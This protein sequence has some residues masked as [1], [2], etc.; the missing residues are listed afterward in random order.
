MQS[1]FSS[2]VKGLQPL[3]IVINLVVTALAL[4]AYSFYPVEQAN[5]PKATGSIT[6]NELTDQLTKPLITA[7][8]EPGQNRASQ[9]LNLSAELNNQFEYYLY[10]YTA[11]K[12]SELVYASKKPAIEPSK[13]NQYSKDDNTIYQQLSLNDQPVGELII[14][15]VANTQIPSHSA[16][17]TYVLVGLALLSL[18]ILTFYINAYLNKRIRKSSDSLASQLQVITESASYDSHVQQQLDLGLSAVASNINKLLDQVQ[19]A[20][21]N[22][23][24]AQSDL[25]S[26]QSDLETEVQKRTMELEKATLRAEQASD[27][28]TTFLATMSHEIRTPMNGVIG[29]IDLL[30]QTEL[31]G[32][33]HRLSTIIRESAFS[34]LGILDDILDFSKIEAG[35]LNIDPT[36]FSVADTIEEV[37]RV[38]SS[39]AKKR[40]LDLELAIAPDIPTNLIG[41]TIR[42]RQVLYNLCSNAIKFTSTDENRRG[43]VRIA[44]EVAQNTTDHFTLR[45]IVSDNGK[46]MSQSQLREIFN[47]F[48]QAENSI[49]REYGGTGLGLSI[50]KSLTELML[51]TIN[52]TSDLGIGSEF[53]V[54]L[55]F[56][57]EGTIKYAHKNT[58][59]DQHVVLISDNNARKQTLARYLS[60]MGAKTSQ[61]DTLSE[62]ERH[63]ESFGIVWVLDGVDSIEKTNSLLRRL[64]YTLEDHKQQIVVLSKLDEAAINHKNIFYLNATPLCKSNFMMS[65]LVA[66]GL[67]TPKQVKPVKTFNNYLNVEQAREE[68]KLILLVEDNLLNQQVLTDQLHLLGYGVEVAENGEQGLQKWREERYSLILTDL[69]MPKMSGYDMVE[70]IRE[71]ASKL[72]D[73]NA[74]PY[75]IAI[76]ANALKG[77]KERCLNAGINDFITKPVELNALEA[78]LETWTQ[79]SKQGTVSVS[80]VSEKP[81][82]PV[83]LEMLAKYVNNDEAKQIRFF[84]MYLEQSNNLT[85]EINSAVMVSDYQSIAQACHQLKSISKTIGAEQVS[86]LA[87]DFEEHCHLENLSSDELIEQ[88]DTLEIEYSRVAQFLKEQVKQADEQEQSNI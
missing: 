51:G 41:D 21:T 78:I 16:G 53:V 56:S 22:N 82:A 30:R 49:T 64:M 57:T 25:I 80:D 39:V 50:C 36:P 44:V 32:A 60:F 66:A 7:L 4:A 83:N 52:V 73:I 18:I 48:I 77:E 28:K 75:V 85:K 1:K 10:R 74:Q 72:A 55:P 88:R 61:A 86:K 46:G 24:A 8:T 6:L 76:T 27:S 59:K 70:I 12:Q 9:L 20:I 43:H 79:K 15:K 40:Q 11:T 14:K 84:K 42:V 26:L 87:A 65:L 33:Q 17:L 63:Q 13:L 2:P 23:N 37:A 71:E 68:N 3:V 35:R 29:T 45:F 34:L 58:L 19:D 38:L 69:H 67:H 54:E 31:N 62:I 81:A 47:P 5:G